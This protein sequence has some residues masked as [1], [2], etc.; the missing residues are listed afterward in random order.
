MTQLAV[1]GNTSTLPQH[2]WH[3]VLDRKLSA[4]PCSYLGS[5]GMLVLSKA[6]EG[7]HDYA[8]LTD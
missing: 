3:M 2:T 8:S 6:S 1:P 7:I 5:L 4:D